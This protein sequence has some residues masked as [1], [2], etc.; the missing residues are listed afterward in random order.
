MTLW[1]DVRYAVR[2]LVREPGFAVLCVVMLALG[3]GAN[4]A[5][6]S[7]VDSV[8]LKELPYRDPARLVSLRE[9]IPAI[10]ATYPTLPVSANHFTQWR[11]RCSSFESLSALSTGTLN[12]TGLGEAER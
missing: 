4:T 6:F 7:I 9:V 12:M 1:L 10:A 8:L 11:Q 2:A 3:I 5:I